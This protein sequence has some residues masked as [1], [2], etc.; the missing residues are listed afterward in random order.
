MS[1]FSLVGDEA[2]GELADVDEEQR[3]GEDPPQV[4]AGEVKPCVVMDL[5]LGALAAP[6]C[7]ANTNTSSGETIPS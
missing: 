1:E 3:E 5:D 4:V 7:Q 2:L 6:P